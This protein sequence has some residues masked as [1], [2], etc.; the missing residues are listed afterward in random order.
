MIERKGA[1]CDPQA[2]GVTGAHQH[3]YAI[4]S[5]G[6]QQRK[7]RVTLKQINAVGGLID[8]DESGLHDK[9][10][11]DGNTRDLCAVQLVASK[12]STLLCADPDQGFLG[13]TS[14]LLGRDTLT[15]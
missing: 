9:G 13:S 7:K 14:C 5:Y 10:A 15:E 6:P 3:G 11:S 8:D 2:G 12:F 1:I 4:V